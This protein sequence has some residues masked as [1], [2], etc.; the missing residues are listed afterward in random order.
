MDEE[1]KKFFK[2]LEQ[3]RNKLITALVFLTEET[4]GLVVHFNGFE[5]ENHAQSF[6][7]RLMKNSGVQY[8]SIKDFI[9]FPTIH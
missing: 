8:T 3:K 1:T 7:N 9:D 2:K 5:N 6:M 4:N